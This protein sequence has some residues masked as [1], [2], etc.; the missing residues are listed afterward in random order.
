M[1][2][3]TVSFASNGAS[4]TIT[5]PI[6]DDTTP[7]LGE[8]FQVEIYN[9][10]TNNVVV[11]PSVA[12]VTIPA[13]DDEHGVISFPSVG[14]SMTLNED[15]AASRSASYTVRRAQGAFGIINVYWRVCNLY[16]DMLRQQRQYCFVQMLVAKSMISKF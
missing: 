11:A 6:T 2:S 4:A 8:T 3:G 15:Q 9:A 12:R 7:E 14:L 13:N 1:S 16:S 5:I 10:S